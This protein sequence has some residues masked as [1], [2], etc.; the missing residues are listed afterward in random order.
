MVQI[1]NTPVKGLLLQQISELIL[2]R[3]GTSMRMA[4]KRGGSKTFVV[5]L[6]R[7]RPREL[8]DNPE[9]SAGEPP[10]TKP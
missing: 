9:E 5:K 1:D 6:T 10:I 2:G 4:L 3:R 8:S 7:N